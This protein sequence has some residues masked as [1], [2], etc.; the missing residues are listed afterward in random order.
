MPE[1]LLHLD[2]TGQ[3][4]SIDGG[5]F[6]GPVLVTGANGFIGR[7][8]CSQLAAAGENVHAVVRASSSRAVAHN[9]EV[10]IHTLRDSISDYAAASD[11]VQ[12]TVVFHLATL[13]QPHHE[14]TE[15]ARMVE[16]NIT[17]G[18]TVADTAMRS[19]ARLIHVTSAWQHYAGAEY[20]PVSLY[21]ATK[22]ALCDIIRYFTEAEGLISDEVCL[23]DTY[24]PC[25]DRKKLMW[26][27]LEHAASGDP[28]PMSS[29]HHLI[30]L[31][32]VDDV[33]AALVQVATGPTLGTRLV[34]RSGAPITIRALAALVEQVTGRAIDTRWDQRPARPREMEENWDVPGAVTSWR[35]NI[36]LTTGVAQLWDERMGRRD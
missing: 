33:V 17:F 20:S 4:M 24:G 21:A 36:D 30:D 16:D 7:H 29:G 18:T 25:D 12:P 14:P 8:L 2:T 22:Q 34:V 1:A 6:A 11:S 19:G 32:H 26:L 28:L 35:P 23:F 27:L 31:T 9:R 3:H 10:T 15:I 13:F 5:R